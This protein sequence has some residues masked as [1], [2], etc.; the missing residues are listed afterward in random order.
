MGSVRTD[1]RDKAV[2]KW[3]AQNGLILINTGK[4]NTC[5]RQGGE[6]IIDL[7][8]ASPAAARRIV[9]WKVAEDR[10]ILSDHRVIEFT[11]SSAINSNTRTG[12]NNKKN[13]P[14]WAIRKLDIDRLGAAIEVT[15]WM[16]SWED[17]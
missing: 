4:V 5:L 10:E 1:A 13:E 12:P 9:S 8:W 17:L 6:S 16:Q 14:R 11:L 2:E 7:T 3:A 15:L